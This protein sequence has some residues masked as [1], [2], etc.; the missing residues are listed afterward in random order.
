MSQFGVPTKRPQNKVAWENVSA[1]GIPRH[2][3]S[4]PS[5]TSR[6]TFTGPKK[7]GRCLGVWAGLALHGRAKS[8]CMCR[9]A[10][11]EAKSG[12]MSDAK[13]PHEELSQELSRSGR[14]C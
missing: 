11:S 4:P 14:R 13:S 9:G 3:P 12:A 6:G 1:S 8:E 7:G 10:K 5:P 2:L